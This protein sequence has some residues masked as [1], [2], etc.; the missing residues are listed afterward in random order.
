MSNSES[1]AC[2]VCGKKHKTIELSFAAHFPDMYAG[3]KRA[4]RDV[5]AVISSD[6]CVVDEKY[7]FIRGCLEVPVIGQS[8]PFLWG[9][10]AMVREHV[11]DEIEECWE[12]EGREKLHGPFKARLANS[13]SVYPET[14][15]LKVKVI[16]QPMGARPLFVCQED[17]HP[18]TLEQRDGISQE[19]AI[20]LACLLLHKANEVT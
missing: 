3:L 15:N 13:L 19:R 9:L 1:W 5:R 7:F 17:H 4:E 12:L 14:F 8:E 2:R 16:L 6:Q 18:L 20:E 10:W 11:F